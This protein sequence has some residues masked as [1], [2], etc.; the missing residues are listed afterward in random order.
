[1]IAKIREKAKSYSNVQESN[2]RNIKNL[3]NQVIT[4]LPNDLSY[5]IDVIT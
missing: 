4:A 5:Y 3:K 1:M 2:N